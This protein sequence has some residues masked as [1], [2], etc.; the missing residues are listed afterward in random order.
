MFWGLL[1]GIVLLV[2]VI[3]KIVATG[4][5]VPFLLVYIVIQCFMGSPDTAFLYLGSFTGNYARCS[6]LLGH[7]TI[8][9]HNDALTQQGS[10][11][12]Y[13]TILA[14]ST[15]DLTELNTQTIRSMGQAL[16]I[17]CDN[18]LGNTTLK[19]A[20]DM[21]IYI[22]AKGFLGFVELPDET[23]IVVGSH[24]YKSHP[25]EQPL[26]IIYSTT[27]LGKTVIERI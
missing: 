4:I 8:N 9:L 24:T 14:S 23:S 12:E 5:I 13:R 19:V 7:A 16:V 11:L 15:I 18:S 27:I 25:Q 17:Q 3:L 10:P 20:K 22:R 2:I 21:P 26:L 6:V 1:L